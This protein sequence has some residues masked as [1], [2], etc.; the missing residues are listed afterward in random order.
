[1]RGQRDGHATPPLAESAERQPCSMGR[2][3]RLIADP[4][5]SARIQ[6]TGLAVIFYVDVGPAIDPSASRT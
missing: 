2:S 6:G 3:K 5:F 1:M 4:F